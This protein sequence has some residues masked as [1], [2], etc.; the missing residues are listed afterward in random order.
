MTS[1]EKSVKMADIAQALGISTV[2]VSKALA[3]RKG[4][5][6][7]LRG[8][9]R[10]L[11]EEMGYQPPAVRRKSQQGEGYNIGVLIPERYLDNYN[12]SFYWKLYQ[13]VTARAMQKGCFTL[14]EMLSEQDAL[15]GKPPKLIAENKVD[16]L[17][18]IGK[19]SHGYAGKIKA[20]WHRPLVFL[21]FYDSYVSADSVISDGFYGMYLMTNYLIDRGHRDIGYVG[22]LLATDSI[23]DR[24]LG[25][26]KALME[27][28][29]PVNSAWLVPD[30]DIGSG[31]MIPMQFS[32][33]MPTAYVCNCDFMASVL[34][35]QLKERGLRVPEDI[36]VVGF[37]DYLFPG[38]C[39]VGI[40]TYA[41]DIHEMAHCAIRVVQ[42]KLSGESYK[43]GMQIMQGYLVERESVRTLKA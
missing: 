4:V 38:P 22:T 23:T 42:R 37:D 15:G 41:V 26:V 5:S 40:T 16:A 14:L 29:L 19:P 21:D 43:T 7:E 11:A 24:Y 25:Y 36:S 17:I 18:I 28:G 10:R 33:K 27:R 30:R 6:E 9:V 39:D 32:E 13:Q 3:G 34:I 31:N 8:R 20:E 2:A 35:G 1:M 12:E